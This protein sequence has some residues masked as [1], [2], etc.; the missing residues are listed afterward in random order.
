LCWFQ[1]PMA[2]RVHR[3]RDRHQHGQPTP[4]PTPL[5]FAR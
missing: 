4:K 1:L 2:H 5:I 3:D